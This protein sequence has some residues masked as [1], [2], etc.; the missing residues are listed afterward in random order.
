[1]LRNRECGISKDAA[2]TRTCQLLRGTVLHF[3]T[4]YTMSKFI[5]NMGDKLLLNFSPKFHCPFI[6]WALKITSNLLNL[7]VI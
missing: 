1:M 4:S 7:I 3:V 2:Y 6:I 5:N